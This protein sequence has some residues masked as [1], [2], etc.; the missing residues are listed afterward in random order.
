MRARSLVLAVLFGLG[1]VVLSQALCDAGDWPAW[2]GPARDGLSE[3][4]GLLQKWPQDGPKLLWTAKGLGSGYGTPSVANGKIYVMGTKTDVG[5]KGKGKGGGFGGGFGGP[6]VPEYL[7]CLDAAKEGKVIW[8]AEIGKTAGMFAGPRCTPTVADGRV[9]VL[10]SNGRLA[11]VSADKGEVIWKKDL[12]DAYGGKK[13]MFGYSESPLV[14]GD[15]LICTP[16]GSKATLLAL[17]AKNGDEVWKSSVTGLKMKQ[18]KGGFGKG[19]G[20]GGGF[21]GF[22]KA[23]EYNTAAYS[24]VIKAEVKGSRQYVQFLSGGV[25][26]V[27]TK[28]GKLLWHYDEPSCGQA[29][30]STPIFRDGAVWAASAYNNGGGK[31]LITEKD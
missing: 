7:F 28:D 16:G 25:V 12:E 27:S 10:S 22:G 24:S 20:K 2:R 26:G 4:S 31:A 23:P 6:S 13:G 9:F 30:C 21:G 5:G 15:V 29:K 19:G 17:K 1:L 18:G 14:D 3:E 8:S 11:C